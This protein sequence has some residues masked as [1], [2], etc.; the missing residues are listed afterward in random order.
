MPTV[1]LPPK[2]PEGQNI[3]LEEARSIVIVG[4]NGAG[5]TRFGAFIE[6]T[7][8]DKAHRVG[9]QRALS[10]PV[11]VQPRSY[12]QAE[13]SLRYG[14]FEPSWKHEQ[15]VANRVGHRWGSEPFTQLLND[16][17][18][19]LA[20]LF[21]DETKRNREFTHSAF[22]KTPQ[23]KP[24]KCK[25]DHLSDIWAAVMPQR[26]LI[27]HDDKIEAKTHDGKA[28]QGRHM[29]DGERVSVYMMGQAL[30]APENGIIIIDEPELHLHRAIQP[31]LWDQIEAKRPDCTF[32]Y[33]THD[34]DFAA[35]RIGAHLIWLERFDGTSWVWHEI[36]T[37]PALPDALL[38]QVLGSRRPLLFVE[39]DDNSYDVA[40]YSALYPKEL[41]V[42][43]KSC[44]KVIEA[45]KAMK[46][47]PTLHHLAV[48]G[49][50]D[51]DRRS[52]EEIAALKNLGIMVA[53]VAE[54][55]NLMCLPEVIDAVAKALRCDDIATIR[56]TAENRVLQELSSQLDQQSLMRSI[57]D[58]QFRLNGFG[59]RIGKMNARQVQDELQTYLSG[60]NVVNTVERN[61]IL[62]ESIVST[63]DYRKAL[64]H[65]N[66]KG[67][68]SFVAKSLGVERE[69]YT[70]I[71][72]KLLKDDAAGL[73]ATAMRK[74]IE[75]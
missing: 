17:E 73:V 49:L 43:C 34:L 3:L 35:T 58:V 9:A 23:N 63:K 32:V 37:N 44:E 21:A 28:Y 27:I 62:L 29:S 64:Q 38:F 53:E 72:L 12:Q 46:S 52:E 40:I 59:P 31:L 67:I 65:Y 66:S 16:Y 19:L 55:E 7:A 30:C 74:A 61:K 41:V 68:V 36:V 15:H 54:V 18:Y 8:G 25:L 50:V 33:I 6:Q 2:S 69:R 60:I 47:L 14:N 70:D 75:L 10:I 20:L 22:E 71:V 42:P 51:R 13:S 4:A 5:K 26:E 57:A 11:F 45:T 56:G 39:G 24:P 1:E 48:R